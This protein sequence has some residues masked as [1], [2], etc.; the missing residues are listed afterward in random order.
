MDR[1]K[2]GEGFGYRSLS[3][4]KGGAQFFPPL[5]GSSSFPNFP[6]DTR[7]STTYRTVLNV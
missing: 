7:P 1:G 5:S 4:R 2:Q 3:P 6:R